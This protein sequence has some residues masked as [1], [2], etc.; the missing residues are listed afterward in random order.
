VRTVV[1]HGDLGQTFT[2]AARRAQII[3][4]AI[5]TVAEVGFARASLAQIG[6]RIG[7]SKG[8]IGYHFAGKEDLIKQVVLEII[9]QGKA[10]MQP[11]ILAHSN[12]PDMLRAYIESNLEFV[13]EHRNHML[14]IAEIARNG[15][16]AD[17]V[18]VQT[19]ADVDAAVHAL[20][21]L[22]ARL[23]AIGELRSDFDPRV[24][25]VL[26]RA[27]IDAV[28]RR[29]AHDPNLDVGKYAT[30]IANVFGLATRPAHP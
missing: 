18:P 10:Y 19:G 4:A 12:G 26:I 23:Q 15:V 30:E 25:A 22:L 8:L 27:A 6:A 1:P 20:E 29:L 3:Q 7:I 17:G 14:A 24:M 21:G 2:E 28:P 16:S 13:K 11:R 5:D 9:E